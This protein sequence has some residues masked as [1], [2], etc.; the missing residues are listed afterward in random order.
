MLNQNAGLRGKRLVRERHGAMLVFVAVVGVVLMG[1]LA[2]TLDIGAGA[3]QRRIAQTA[4]DAGAIGGGQE[5]LRKNY[6]DVVAAAQAEAVQNGYAL[7]DVTVHYPPATGAF[8]GNPQYVEVLINKTIPTIFGSIFSV[9]SMNV[10]ARGVAGVSSYALNCLYSLNPDGAGS[11]SVDPGGELNTNCGVVVNSTNSEAVD[12]GASGKVIVDGSGIGIAGSYTGGGG[13]VITPTPQT[14]VAP[15]SNPLSHISMP[16]V[17]ACDHT[18]LTTVSG[19]QTLN[20]GVYCGGISVGAGGGGGAGSNVAT[21]NPGTYIMAGG[22]LTVGNSGT[23]IGNGV[24]LIV[25]TGSYAFKAFEFGTGCKVKLTAPTSGDFKGIVMYQDP[26]APS[27]PGSTFA[28]ASDDYPEVTGSIY[29][30]NSSILF[31]GSNTNTTIM[32]A[33]LASTVVVSGK[34]NIVA[35]T[36]GN[37]ATQRLALVQ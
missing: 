8:A 10:Q 1:F 27:T 32:G 4:A 15:A 5:I 25:T 30:P 33:V 29:L 37:T 28:C 23:L 34:I 16:T 31:N 3:R 12:L 26:A 9:A 19:A 18:G 22:G 35:E 6:F 24:T 17:G 36:S 11:L 14:G 13:S 20:P 2:M 21:L 7:G